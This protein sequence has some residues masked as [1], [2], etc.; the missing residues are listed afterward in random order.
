MTYKLH[1]EQ[2][3]V[4]QFTTTEAHFFGSF[5]IGNILSSLTIYLMAINQ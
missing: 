3:F 2:L 1:G 5:F 4:F